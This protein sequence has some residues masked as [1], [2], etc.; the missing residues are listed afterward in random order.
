MEEVDMGTQ[1]SKVED[2]LNQIEPMVNKLSSKTLNERIITAGNSTASSKQRTVELIN[3]YGRILSKLLVSYS[4]LLGVENYKDTDLNTEV[5]K[6]EE[7]VERFNRHVGKIQKSESVAKKLLENVFSAS[8][9]A[10]SPTISSGL[11]P[12]SR[13]KKVKSSSCSSSSSNSLLLNGGS[14]RVHKPERPRK[15]KKVKRKAQ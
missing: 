14:A 2:L 6:V 13:A 12:A 3:N 10:S 11:S 7:Y 5:Q 9:S 1:I 15:H 4:E 8:I